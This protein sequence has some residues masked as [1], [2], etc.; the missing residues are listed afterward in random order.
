MTPRP[1]TPVPRNR[2]RVG[3]VLI[4]LLGLYLA[5]IP[6]HQAATEAAFSFKAALLGP[7]F[8]VLGL[9][10]VAWPGYKEERLARGEDISALQGSALITP[11]WWGVLV[12]A[13]ASG[14]AYV[15]ALRNGWLG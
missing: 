14:G 6:W 12:V 7:A 13:L 9:A 10:L 4:A 3:G 15:L 5:S 1:Y 2:Q 8:T 11:R